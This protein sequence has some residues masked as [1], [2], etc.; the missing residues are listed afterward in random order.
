MPGDTTWNVDV[1]Y[2]DKP[3]WIIADIVSLVTLS[4]LLG[5]LIVDAHKKKEERNQGFSFHER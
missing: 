1:V 2:K 5:M 3:L 4:C